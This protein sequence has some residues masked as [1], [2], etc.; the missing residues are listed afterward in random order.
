[1]LG[2]VPLDIE[3]IEQEIAKYNESFKGEEPPHVFTRRE[4]QSYLEGLV[5]HGM[6]KVTFECDWFGCGETAGIGNRCS[7]H[8]LLL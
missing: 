1:M 2:D 4:L 6:A 3:E 7:K 5:K 8:R